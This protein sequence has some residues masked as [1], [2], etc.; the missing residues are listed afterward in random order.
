MNAFKQGALRVLIATDVAARG[1]KLYFAA[2]HKP[3]YA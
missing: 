1:K 2:M 3:V